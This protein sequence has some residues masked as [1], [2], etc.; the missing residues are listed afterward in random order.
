MEVLKICAAATVAVFMISVLKPVKKEFAIAVS[1]V[2]GVFIFSLVVSYLKSIV[3]TVKSV[4]TRFNIDGAMTVVILKIIGVAYICE[5]AS[6]ICKDAGE[7]A[8]AAKVE[9]GGK[10]IIVYLALPIITSLLDLLAKFL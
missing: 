2:C 8:I 1:I 5:F 7:S 10:I 6:G 3:G 9:T 4:F